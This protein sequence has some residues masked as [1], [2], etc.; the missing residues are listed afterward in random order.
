MRRGDL[1]SDFANRYGG[2]SLMHRGNRRE[3][4]FRAN[5]DRR[6]F[7]D[8]QGE[9]FAKT[10]WPESGEAKAERWVRKNTARRGGRKTNRPA[11]HPP[12]ARAATSP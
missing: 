7:L 8:A 3:P 11:S 12:K 10:D 6:R 2:S 1:P 5:A 4:I 9:A